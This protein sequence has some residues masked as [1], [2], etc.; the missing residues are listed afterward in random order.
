VLAARIICGPA[1]SIFDYSPRHTPN[2]QPFTELG[3]DLLELLAA[4]D[5]SVQP[6]VLGSLVK[7][8]PWINPLLIEKA[9]SSDPKVAA[10]ADRVLKAPEQ[11]GSPPSYAP[12]VPQPYAP[13]ISPYAPTPSPG[14]VEPQIPQLSPPAVAPPAE[15]SGLPVL[16]D[17][18]E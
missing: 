3:G 13:A 10:A 11:Y 15:P 16:K 17:P 14:V 6:A 4:G 1:P 2:I 8:R 5:A 7:L 9:N 18:P 12:A